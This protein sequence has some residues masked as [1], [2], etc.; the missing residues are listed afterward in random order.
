MVIIYGLALLI[1]LKNA[2]IYA[3]EKNREADSQLLS[4][5]ATVLP[6]VDMG[7]NIMPHEYFKIYSNHLQRVFSEQQE[8]INVLVIGAC[9]GTEDSFIDN[10]YRTSNTWEGLFIEPVSFNHKDLVANITKDPRT[11]GRSHVVR[12]AVLDECKDPTVSILRPIFEDTN[13]SEPHWKRRQ[14]AKV[15]DKNASASS[16]WWTKEHV[17]CLTPSQ[18]I[19]AWR[20]L[21]RYKQHSS[22]R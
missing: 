3:R 17:R 20:S 22:T 10:T 18:L 21:Q 9:D 11:A 13:T 1:C 12:G 6:S 7:P 14:I 15:I 19:A 4:K 5:W 8:S 2:H 16:R